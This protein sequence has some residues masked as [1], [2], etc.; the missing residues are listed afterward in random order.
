LKLFILLA[1]LSADVYQLPHESVAA[2]RDDAR[3]AHA[4]GKLTTYFRYA[5]I[6]D[7]DQKKARFHTYATNECI[8]RGDLIVHP[9][10]FAAGS[11]LR[12]D[13]F[14][15]AGG[16]EK[17][18]KELLAIWERF[19]R[20]E[21]YFLTDI[22]ED[23]HLPPG[24]VKVL[25]ESATHYLVEMDKEFTQDGKPYKAR[26]FTRKELGKKTG[27]RDFSPTCGL[28]ATEELAEL[29]GT[30]VPIV[31]LAWFT[32]RMRS[33]IERGLYHEFR[34]IEKTPAKGTAQEAFLAKL[35]ADEVDSD[36]RRAVYESI[37]DFSQVHGKRRRT[38]IFQSRIPEPSVAQGIVSITEDP[39]DD[40]TNPE[41]D[42]LV[43]ARKSKFAATEIIAELET[44]LHV[45]GLFN[46]KGELQ[47]EAPPN[48]VADHNIPVPYTKIL[49]NCESCQNCHNMK[50]KNGGFGWKSFGDDFKAINAK[51]LDI[52]GEKSRFK[53]TKD[54]DTFV[55]A[56]RHKGDAIKILTRA[57]GCPDMEPQEV[58]DGL[59]AMQNE[60]W[61]GRIDAAVAC[62]EIGEEVPEGITAA[63][64]LLKTIALPV[65]ADGYIEEHPTFGLLYAGLS[66]SRLRWEEVYGQAVYRKLE[67]KR[68][69]Q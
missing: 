31:D 13:F 54:D 30:R 44:G 35:G 33:P 50:E 23:F 28:D 45:Y 11:V 55:L 41:F 52:F 65:P 68:L 32:K 9:H 25:E 42:P 66:T 14:R 36:N 51:R 24:G 7:K 47:N 39:I 48:V 37:I 43:N 15:L 60:Y 34:G 67:K 22:I 59:T 10:L 27:K 26:W 18:A 63:D 12:W 20:D 29:T 57:R 19:E 46:G 69:A 3:A 64:H 61:Y 2:A 58:F 56:S 21:P 53:G 38:R 40:E 5:A 49:R 62:R 4:E 17:V 6:R 8:T 16:D 1:A